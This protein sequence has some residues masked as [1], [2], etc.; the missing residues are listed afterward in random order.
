MT[1]STPYPAC[2]VDGVAVEEPL[3][4][5]K[6]SNPACESEANVIDSSTVE[7]S[8]STSAPSKDLA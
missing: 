5:A 4:V 6:Q 8:W 7:I 1:P 2:Q 3:W